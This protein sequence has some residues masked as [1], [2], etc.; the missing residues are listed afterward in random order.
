VYYPVAL[1]LQECFAYLGC[2]RGAFPESELAAEQTLA[3]PVY[4][5]LTDAQAQYVVECVRDFFAVK[6]PKE[7][8]RSDR[9]AVA[10]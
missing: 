6:S 5:E 4:P 7:S 1:H 2:G 3:L 9:H 8:G 10:E